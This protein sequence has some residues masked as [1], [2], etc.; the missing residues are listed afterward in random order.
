[1]A[2]LF[3]SKDYI[4]KDDVIKKSIQRCEKCFNVN[5]GNYY[6]N[7]NGKP[8]LD[9]GFI[10]ISHTDNV[11]LVAISLKEPIGVDIEDKNRKIND[12]INISIKQWTQKEAYSKMIG[13]GINRDI[14]NRNDYY[15]TIYSVECLEDY[16]ISI[17]SLDKIITINQL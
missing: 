9:K 14:L 6:K 4:D 11:M 7:E 10:S 1:M 2:V 3:I 12:K 13:C 8:M 16:Y 5:L 17:S 15:D